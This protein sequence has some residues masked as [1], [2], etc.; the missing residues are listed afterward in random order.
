MQIAI[1]ISDQN[2]GCH[3]HIEYSTFST[4]LFNEKH[5]F[6]DHDQHK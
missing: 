5:F 3:L 6:F 2:K 4:H 1:I